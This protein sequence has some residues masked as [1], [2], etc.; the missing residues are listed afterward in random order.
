MVHPPHFL[1]NMGANGSQ[2]VAHGA[3]RGEGGVLI[4]ACLAVSLSSGFVASHV[5]APTHALFLL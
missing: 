4:F 3:E 1:P 2:S 5:D